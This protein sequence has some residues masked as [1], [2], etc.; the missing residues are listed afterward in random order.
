M[1]LRKAEK[2][3]S[4]I[5]AEIDYNSLILGEETVGGIRCVRVVEDLLPR[6][7]E[8]EGSARAVGLRTARLTYWSLFW[9][10]AVDPC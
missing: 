9:S 8:E 7:K 1:K 10:T 4:D 5:R 2:L 3:R 6:A